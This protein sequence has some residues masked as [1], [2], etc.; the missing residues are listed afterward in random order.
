[1]NMNIKDLVSKYKKVGLK[2]SQVVYITSDFGKLISNLNFNK[3][4]VLSNHFDAIQS[5]VGKNGTIVVPTATLNLCGT[6]KVFVPNDTQSY[7]MGAFSE[8]VRKKK[9]SKRSFHPLWSVSAYGKHAEYITSNIPQN[10]FGYNSAFHRL[11]KK[12]AFCLCIGV[13]PRKSISTKTILLL[14]IAEL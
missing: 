3:N 10:A 14:A 6:N 2:K 8:Y 5:I 1:M 4:K 7:E 12:N 13:D 9:G 11:V